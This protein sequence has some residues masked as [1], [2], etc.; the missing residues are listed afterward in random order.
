MA[1]CSIRLFH[2]FGM[3][4]VEITFGRWENTSTQNERYLLAITAFVFGFIQHF[5]EIHVIHD[6]CETQKTVKSKNNSIS[7][8]LIV[9]IVINQGKTHNGIP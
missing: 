6:H 1:F 2:I 3:T 7:G 8:M 9:C 5:I 4:Y